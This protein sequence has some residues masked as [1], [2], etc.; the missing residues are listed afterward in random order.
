MDQ[1]IDQMDSSADHEKLKQMSR[2]NLNQMIPQISH[3]IAEHGG[4]FGY[5]IHLKSEIH[6]EQ[7]A[8]KAKGLSS[9]DRSIASQKTINRLLVIALIVGI[10]LFIVGI[11]GGLG[12]LSAI[13]FSVL[14]VDFLVFCA[15]P[16][17][18]CVIVGTSYAGFSF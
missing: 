12:A 10:I 15:Q 6:K 5:L 9:I 8:L 13:G 11:S 3:S 4:V 16:G 14:F 1:H 7:T 18:V 17:A 2:E